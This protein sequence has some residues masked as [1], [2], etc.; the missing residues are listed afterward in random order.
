M[1]RPLSFYLP[2]Q[3]ALVLGGGGAK[4]A[5]E[6]GV[7]DSMEQLGIRAGSV[8][9][10]S[11]GALNGAMYAGGQMDAAR[12]LWASLRT[13]DVIDEE[14]A[15]LA[16]EAEA[17]FG[18]ADKLLEFI[19]RHSPR[20]GAAPAPMAQLIR[21][22]ISEDAA[23]KSGVLL[24]LVATHFPSL[25]LVEKQLSDMPPGSLHDWLI[26]ATACYPLFPMKTIGEEKYLDG[27][28][29]DNVPVDMALR[30]GAQQIIAVDIGRN[31]AHPTYAARPNVIYIRAQ[32]PLG[33]LLTFDPD[34]SARSWQLGYQDAM[35]AFGRLR[36]T[37]YAFDPV[38]AQALHN[39]AQAFFARITRYEADLRRQNLFARREEP[40]FA[41]LQ[42]RLCPGADA[43]DYFLRACELCAET[44]AIDPAGTYT[45]D[46]MKEAL[47]DALPLD[48]AQQMLGSLLG[49]RIGVLFAKPQ[50]DQK[51]VLACL[52]ILL[53][54]ETAFPPIALR[55]L[56][57][58]PRELLCALTLREIL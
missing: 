8:Y 22:T 21:K 53:S 31:P 7:I 1:Q 44:L 49:G 33:G 20:G 57:A 11:I 26:A 34:R 46:A 30:G 10:A 6:I 50:P 58:F 24:G 2:S 5:Y 38:D 27:G 16:E 3:T 55:T 52:Y 12:E 29:L 54:R 28:F 9:G 43:I 25:S 51:L 13:S 45:F 35:R 36:G 41:L 23:R 32:H 19:T 42:E 15:A 40:F 18:R 17:I 56:C 4:G 48:S 37:R 14:N 47:R 39:R